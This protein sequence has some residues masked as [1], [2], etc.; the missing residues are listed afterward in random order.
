MTWGNRSHRCLCLVLLAVWDWVT[1]GTETLLPDWPGA[2]LFPGDL[3]REVGWEPWHTSHVDFWEHSER[4]WPMLKQ[5]KHI[6]RFM[7]NAILSL[8]NNWRNFLHNRNGCGNEQKVHRFWTEVDL[9]APDSGWTTAA[10]DV[11]FLS[12]REAFLL[13][14]EPVFTF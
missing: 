8:C 7:R 2:L 3:W 14:S 10:A 4:M 12:V 13:R 6:L 11:D 5:S 9:G 1:L